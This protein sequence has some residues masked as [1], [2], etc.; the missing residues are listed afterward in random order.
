MHIHARTYIYVPVQR[1]VWLGRHEE[2]T[3]TAEDVPHCHTWSVTG[4]KHTMADPPT[5]VD[6]TMINLH[7]YK[8]H[9]ASSITYRFKV[10]SC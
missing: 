2:P 5:T 1:I 3:N 7:E 8:E 9:K 6:V 4:A 10:A